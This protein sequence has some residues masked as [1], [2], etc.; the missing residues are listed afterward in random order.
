MN[1]FATL[2]TFSCK[3]G[4]VRHSREQIEAILARE[5][6]RAEANWYSQQAQFAEIVAAISLGLPDTDGVMRIKI[7]ADHHNRALREYRTALSEFTAFTMNLAVP[8]R[9]KQ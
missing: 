9:F 1:P 3:N 5:V 4:D 2:L 6:E 7:A 8:E